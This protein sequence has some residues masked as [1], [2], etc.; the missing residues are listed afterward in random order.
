MSS[1][2]VYLQ[3]G[4][5]FRGLHPLG[6]AT[7]EGGRYYL[8]CSCKNAQL[9]QP[10][11]GFACKPTRRPDGC[12]FSTSDSWQPCSSPERFE[13][14][15]RLNNDGYG[16]FRYN[17]IALIGTS[18]FTLC[19]S[20]DG[21]SGSDGNGRDVRNNGN[22][23]GENG[24]PDDSESAEG[25]EIPI[26]FGRRSTTYRNERKAS[27]YDRNN[28]GK[29]LWDKLDE[30]ASQNYLKYWGIQGRNYSN[31]V[32]GIF[33]IIGR[34][35]PSDF[36]NLFLA[37]C[38]GV[39]GLWALS[40]RMASPW[41]SNFMQRNF[42]TSREAMTQRRY[43]TLLT[44][45]ISHTGFMHL[46]LN[47]TMF[48][49]LISTFKQNMRGP[50][51]PP[52]PSSSFDNYIGDI[53]NSVETFLWGER[54]QTGQRHHVQTADIVNVMLLSAVGSS[55]GHVYLYRTPVIGASGAISGLLYLLA[56]T[57]PNSYFRS[58]FPIPGL[59]LSILQV[60]QIFVVTN[61]YFLYYGSNW[62]NVAWAAHL[63]GMGTGALYCLAQQYVFNRPGFHN[64]VRM[65]IVS[66]K[67]QWLR[68][69]KGIGI[70]H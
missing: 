4:R 40:A 19:R 55:L 22:R 23:E 2:G 20:R 66:A 29:S 36:G 18:T 10:K 65:S 32:L 21:S 61:L 14:S 1:V 37:G 63:F 27:H 16:C 24:R 53:F 64:A 41:L 3:R 8:F 17:R 62:R 69:L 47:C 50:S 58:V 39:F 12:V 5:S 70:G 51:S 9:H 60:C 35:S 31:S 52:W 7:V 59:Q 49:Q 28:L 26:E 43:H 33:P 6:R 25:V 13:R 56:S 38:C 34:A 45:A 30:F 57:F 68:T 42:V 46:F 48:H 67:R 15:Y 11:P 54:S 44:C